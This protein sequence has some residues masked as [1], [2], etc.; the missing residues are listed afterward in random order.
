MVVYVDCMLGVV[1]RFGI[2]WGR[3][4]MM[5][6]RVKVG[7]VLLIEFLSL[8]F[9]SFLIMGEMMLF[10]IFVIKGLRLLYKVLVLLRGLLCV[11]K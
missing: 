4:I 5:E 8:S 2:G 10:G 11:I 3:V 7:M 1:G 9:D 6:W